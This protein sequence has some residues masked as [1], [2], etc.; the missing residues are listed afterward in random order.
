MVYNRRK[1]KK[2][3]KKNVGKYRRYKKSPQKRKMRL[4]GKVIKASGGMTCLTYHPAKNK[5]PLPDQ[6]ITTVR[7]EVDGWLGGVTG[8]NATPKI[9][10]ATGI[11]SVVAPFY[12]G[13]TAYTAYDAFADAFNVNEP[14]YTYTLW[15]AGLDTLLNGNC[16][17][18]FRVLNSTLKV[19]VTLPGGY[20]T[21]TPQVNPDALAV[22][23]LPVANINELSRLAPPGGG[24]ITLVRPYSEWCKQPFAKSKVFRDIGGPQSVSLS[25]ADHT[26]YGKSK[27]AFDC[28]LSGTHT[29]FWN[30]NP[31][32]NSAFAVH[33]QTLNNAG[34]YGNLSVKCELTQ[35]VQLYNLTAQLSN[36]SV[37]DEG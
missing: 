26:L 14:T 35:K 24:G 18:E 29:G 28:D 31:P 25:I 27:L 36:Y 20:N 1:F 13:G 21:L 32:S 37:P 23:I 11:S 33:L 4:A 17:T 12:T 5:V 8:I 30:R 10:I 2:Y 15:P 7:T 19:S 3:T 6:F 16:Y 9:F 22:T 34:I